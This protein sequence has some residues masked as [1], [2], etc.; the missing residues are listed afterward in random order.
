MT[1]ITIE[2]R[3]LAAGLRKILRY[4]FAK[5]SWK[6]SDI[7]GRPSACIMLKTKKRE[8]EGTKKHASSGWSVTTMADRSHYGRNSQILNNT[9]L[10]KFLRDGTVVVVVVIVVVIQRNAETDDERTMLRAD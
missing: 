4:D 9:H 7:T 10:L 8:E 5:T 6:L 3:L 1:M 2:I